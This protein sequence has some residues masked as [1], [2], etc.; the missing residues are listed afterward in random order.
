MIEAKFAEV[1]QND[2][3]AL[4]FDWFLGNFLLNGG[5]VGAQGGSA[6]SVQGR[7]STANPNG[8]FPGTPS[9]FEQGAIQ[10]FRQGTILPTSPSDQLLTSGV[11]N[12]YSKTSGDT[13]QIPALA[14]IS[15]I[16]TDPQFRV[17]I[18]ALQQREGVDL[19]SAPK[20]TTLSGRQAQIQVAWVG[21]ADQ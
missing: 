4:G 2:S 3:K 19:I 15:G 8:I 6:S 13:A 14:S 18:R 17:V 10:T 20:V 11:R 16:L 5:K 21:L 7:Q 12:Q 1:S 9:Y